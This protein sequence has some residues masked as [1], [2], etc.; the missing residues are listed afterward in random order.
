MSQYGCDLPTSSGKHLDSVCASIEDNLSRVCLAPHI[1]NL[2]SHL[3]I[4]FRSLR[5]DPRLVVTKADKGNAVVLLDALQY[6]ELA[7]RLLSDDQ[8]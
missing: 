5:L 1:L 6:T 2:P 7:W 8:T 3:R 4:A